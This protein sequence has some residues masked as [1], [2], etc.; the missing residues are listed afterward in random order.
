MQSHTVRLSK[1]DRLKI[2]KKISILMKLPFS[3][4]HSASPSRMQF[5]RCRINISNDVMVPYPFGITRRGYSPLDGNIN[6]YGLPRIFLQR[7]YTNIT[8]SNYHN[9]S[10]TPIGYSVYQLGDSEYTKWSFGDVEF[11]NQGDS[12]LVSIGLTPPRNSS[13][14]YQSR[15]YMRDIRIRYK[16][17]KKELIIKTNLDKDSYDT[18]KILNLINLALFNAFIY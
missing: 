11:T 5:Q 7:C 17:E 9:N 1:S 10:L 12:C 6:S 18:E 14:R 4:Q 2:K 15:Y 8:Q 16:P 3:F 13:S